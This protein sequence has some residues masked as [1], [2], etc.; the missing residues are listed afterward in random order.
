MEEIFGLDTDIIMLGTLVGFLVILFGVG[1]LA[2]FNR[3]VLKIGL[4]NIPRRPAQTTLI[5]VG[6][7]LSTL[8]IR[9]RSE[10]A[11]RSTTPSK[12]RSPTA[13]AR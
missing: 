3:I 8:I 1:T 9:P 4:R 11:T 10:P 2:V 6:L 5:V 13:W 7:M 12:V